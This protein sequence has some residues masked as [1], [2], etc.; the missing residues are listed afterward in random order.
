MLI[1][2]CNNS[3]KLNKRCI[4][5]QL[6]FCYINKV[7]DIIID[8]PSDSYHSKHNFRY[9]VNYGFVPNTKAADGEEIDAYVLGVNRPLKKYKG[10]CIAIIHRINDDDDK[11]I[12]VPQDS[13]LNTFTDK[14]IKELTHF[15]EQY[16]TSV[17]VR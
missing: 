12:V 1:M 14:K 2:K 9:E 4:C 11:L 6:Y 17:I 13:D 15:Q 3:N 8:R 5:K 10:V 16:F 7:V